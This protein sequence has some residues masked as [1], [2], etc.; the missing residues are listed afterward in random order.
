MRRRWAD[1]THRFRRILG[2]FSIVGLLTGLAPGPLL[3]APPDPHG[4]HLRAGSFDPVREP[5]PTR[6]LTARV[7]YAEGLRGAHLVQF[8]G[9]IGGAQRESL[10]ALGIAIGGSLPSR[11]LE[12]V[13]TEAQRR[14]VARLP[15]VR[16]VG[17]YQDEWKI[18]PRLLDALEAHRAP[19]RVVLRV[20]LFASAD[21]EGIAAL[22]ALGG[23][24]RSHDRARS[25]SLVDIELSTARLHALLKEPLV[26]HVQLV[27]TRVFHNDRAR[28]HMGLAAI[29][30]DTFSSGLDPSLDGFDEASG[31][32]VK[33]G[34]TDS[35]IWTVHPDFQAGISAGRITWEEG[36]AIDDPGGHGTH[37]AGSI[38]GDGSSWNS[39]P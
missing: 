31:F 29:A 4:I 9:P 3:A 15:D 8:E 16:W 17:P 2:I 23:R 37:T 38:I 11:V 24:V 19:R 27:P 36:S 18:T 33:Y 21:E 1:D 39:V 28:F 5:P 7:R 10:E 6:R 34:H 22:R 12:V 32:R 26:R 35:G 30:D 14:A 13:M 25:F 20:S